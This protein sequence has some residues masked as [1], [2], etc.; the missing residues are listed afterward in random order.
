[1][2]P[3]HKHPEFWVLCEEH[4]GGSDP[5]TVV[6]PGLGEA[7]A[8]FS[9]GEEALLYALLSGGRSDR[10]VTLVNAAE[11]SALLSGPRS[12][13]EQVALDPLPGPSS[14]FVNR[15]ASMDRDTFLA[16]LASRV[17]K[18]RVV[19]ALPGARR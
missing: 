16:L 12:R 2:A 1:M 15:P 14:G 13:F 4:E 5:L 9:F 6:L 17:R 8:V 18:T 3:T 19:V 7:L 11:L 10:W